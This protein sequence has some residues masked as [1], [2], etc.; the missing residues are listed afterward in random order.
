[1]LL[2]L[3]FLLTSLFCDGYERYTDYKDNEVAGLWACKISQTPD[4]IA[5]MMAFI[6]AEDNKYII[7]DSES[8]TAV[9][10]RVG[11][12]LKYTYVTFYNGKPIIVDIKIKQVSGNELRIYAESTDLNLICQKYSKPI[13]IKKK[14]R[15]DGDIINPKIKKPFST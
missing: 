6:K 7:I 11:L 10:K 4:K 13:D 14:K 5:Y 1:M 12:W 3:L 9:V 15:Q 2:S 8:F